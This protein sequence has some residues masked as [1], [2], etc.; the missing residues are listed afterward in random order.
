MLAGDSARD[1]TD[2]MK[3]L[4]TALAIAFSACGSLAASHA[5]GAPV[6]TPAQDKI[7]LCGKQAGDK[8]GK[9]RDDFMKTCLS[10]K[11]D[12]AASPACE[13]SADEKKLA[14]AARSGHIKKCMADA[15]GAKKG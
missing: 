14:G 11:K 9:E 1:E 2:P 10:A 12:M 3:Q 8:T 13:K 7:A 4:I 5:A 6:K 15:P